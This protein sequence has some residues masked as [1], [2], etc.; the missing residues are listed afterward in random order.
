MLSPKL[1]AIRDA[2]QTLAEHGLAHLTAE[3][4]TIDGRHVTLGGRRVVQFGSCSYV[5]LEIDPRLKQGACDAIERFGTQFA[6]SRAYLSCPLYSELDSLLQS[7]FGSHVVVAQTTSLA[8]FA[9]LPVLVGKG[10][11][12]VFDQF[13]HASAKAVAPTL[14]EAGVACSGVPHNDVD[15]LERRIAELK[16]H[17][18]HIWYICDGIYSMGGDAAPMGALREMLARHDQLH[19]YID[20]SHGVSWTGL[21][22]RGIAFGERAMHPR[23]V[24]VLSLAKAFS[25]SGAAMVFPD[26]E[27][28]KLIRTCGSTMI[29]SGPLQPALLGSAVASARIHLSD[30]LDAIQ[31]RLRERIDLFNSLASDV[32]L[33]LTTMA[34]TPIRFVR[35]GPEAEAIEATKRLLE[36]G[37]YANASTFPAVPTG[38]AG[39]RVALTVH[40]TLDDVRELVGVL[41]SLC[42]RTLVTA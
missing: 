28:A 42:R 15:A 37:Y 9:A 41:S 19:L 20:D 10:D 35:I 38:E 12:V 5:G 18:R 32:E 40:H 21:H 23:T 33:P 6:S 34:A 30:E 24:V 3:D 25:A 14:R 1:T 39:I 36:K 7:I 31:R 16:A 8:H 22:G 4:A 27:T 26:F 2:L 13:V 29:F 17:H 11:A